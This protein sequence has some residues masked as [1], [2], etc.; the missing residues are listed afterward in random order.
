MSCTFTWANLD[1]QIQEKVGIPL[2]EYIEES[3]TELFNNLSWFSLPEQLD[4]IFDKIKEEHPWAITIS[5]KKFMWYT[6][7]KK[8]EYFC[9]VAY[10]IIND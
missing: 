1:K 10:I 8:A 4:T 3:T 5:K 2:V 7:N 6:L 9:E